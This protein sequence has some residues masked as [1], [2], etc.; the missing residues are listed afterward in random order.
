MPFLA[1]LRVRRLNTLGYTNNRLTH[2]IRSQDEFYAMVDFCNPGALGPP[3]E[4]RRRYEGPI[5]AGELLKLQ[6]FWVC[7]NTSNNS[8]AT[9]AIGSC[10][11]CCVVV[12][13][14]TVKCRFCH[15]S[16]AK[17]R[18]Y[19][20]MTKHDDVFFPP[21]AREPGASDSEVALGEERSTELSTLVNNFILRRTNSL[22]S[23]HLP[24]KVVQASAEQRRSERQFHA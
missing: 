15:A 23:E 11:N 20:H 18:L 3:A 12:P 21:A 6:M 17:R 8:V 4:F 13:P 19:I 10:C 1:A 7:S 16:R 5:L 24:P 9:V 14:S 2:L 22:L